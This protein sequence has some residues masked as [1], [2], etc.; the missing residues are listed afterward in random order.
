MV[1]D[2]TH[3]IQTGQISMVLDVTHW[4]QTGQ[5][6]VVLDVTHWIQTGQACLIDKTDNQA[7]GGRSFI[8]ITLI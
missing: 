3:W 6:S 1:L 2:V 5:I 4:I 8:I 7:V